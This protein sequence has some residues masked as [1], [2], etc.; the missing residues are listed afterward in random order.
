[1]WGF[2]RR[3]GRGLATTDNHHSPFRNTGTR[4]HSDLC[5]CFFFFWFYLFV[6]LSHFL[7]NTCSSLHWILACLGSFSFMASLFLPICVRCWTFVNTTNLCAHL[8]QVWGINSRVNVPLKWLYWKRLQHRCVA[9]DIGFS[10]T[11]MLRTTQWASNQ[12]KMS[13]FRLCWTLWFC[14]KE[15]SPKTSSVFQIILHKKGNQAV[16]V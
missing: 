1:M 14:H 8:F 3:N 15:E 13:F 6:C 10:L 11:G 12:M 4:I 7:T 16:A 5:F 9:A 2:W